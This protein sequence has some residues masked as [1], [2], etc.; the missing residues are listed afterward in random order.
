MR[1]SNLTL[2]GNNGR[3]LVTG[4][5]IAILAAASVALTSANEITQ[6]SK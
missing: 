2:R 6:N 5:A 4:F 1:P 3:Y